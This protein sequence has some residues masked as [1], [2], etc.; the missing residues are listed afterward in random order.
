MLK[1]IIVDD[2]NKICAL[3]QK[4]VDWDKLNIELVGTADNGPSALELIVEHRPDI[5]ITDIRMPGFEGIELIQK[6]RDL[7]IPSSFVI[8]SGYKQFD[9][10]HRALKYGVHDYLL[11][12]INADELNATLEKIS[13]Q[14]TEDSSRLTNEDRLRKTLEDNQ[15]RLRKLFVSKVASDSS[16]ERSI[17]QVNEAYAFSFKE[18]YFEALILHPEVPVSYPQEQLSR[19]LADTIKHV[20]ISTSSVCDESIVFIKWNQVIAVLNFT[21]GSIDRRSVYNGLFKEVTQTSQGHIP[22]TIA[23]GSAESEFTM[24][25]RSITYA[26]E[27]MQC[28]LT[29][30]TGK[31]IYYSSLHYNKASLEEYCGSK[32]INQLTYSVTAFDI[33]SV[34]KIINDTFTWISARTNVS[35]TVYFDACSRIFFSIN[36]VLRKNGYCV[37]CEEFEQLPWS[38]WASSAQSLQSSLSDW[39]KAELERCMEKSSPLENISIRQ[40]KQYIA[41]HF[42]EPITLEEVAGVVHLNLYYLS[43]A[44]KR[45]EGTNFNRYI[46]SLRIEAAKALLRS[47]D[48]SVSQI[49]E[50]V[51]YH[52]VKHFRKL[53]QQEAGI[54]PTEYRKLYS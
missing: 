30:G 48:F 31:I 15:E 21:D 42:A 34:M 9:Y 41:E 44:F 5:V 22:F 6:T 49:A 7:S 52:D 29:L 3:I 27:A 47:S 40:A 17:Q 38:G 16:D 33:N 12:P 25:S 1:A 43:A 50:K 11:K 46:I 2:E 18:G 26:R 51:G 8:I 39:V 24:I 32:W 37:S 36:E 10:A 20:N 54:K 19:I 35:P 14:I 53:F 28:R 4:L 23:I 45:E 13:G